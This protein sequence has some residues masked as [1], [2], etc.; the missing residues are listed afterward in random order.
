MSYYIHI[1]GKYKKYELRKLTA[2]FL[3]IEVKSM[4]EL[5]S[6]KSGIVNIQLSHHKGD[7]PTMF[8]VYKKND[9]CPELMEVDFAIFLAEKLNV[10]ILITYWGLD[11]YAWILVKP[12]GRLFKVDEHPVEDIDGIILYDEYIEELDVETVRENLNE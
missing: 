8:I 10:E 5:F 7:F 4:G 2:A 9:F 6:P 12:D 11:P 3:K 1:K